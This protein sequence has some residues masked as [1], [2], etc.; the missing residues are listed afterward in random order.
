MAQFIQ[1]LDGGSSSS[2]LSMQIYINFRNRLNRCGAAPLSLR[3]MAAVN[4]ETLRYAV[5]T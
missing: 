3:Y 2:T 1:V 5:A 4:E